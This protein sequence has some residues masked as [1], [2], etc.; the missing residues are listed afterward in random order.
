[1]VAHPQSARRRKVRDSEQKFFGSF[2]QKRTF[3]FVT[4]QVGVFAWRTSTR[5]LHFDR[6]VFIE[7]KP[8]YLARHLS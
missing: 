1:M 6:H 8:G 5:F 3:F 4:A 2:F 7:E